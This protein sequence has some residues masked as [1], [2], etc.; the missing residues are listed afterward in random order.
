M[1]GWADPGADPMGDLSKWIET[2]AA[3]TPERGDAVLVLPDRIADACEADPA[4][5]DGPKRVAAAMGFTGVQVRRASD[6]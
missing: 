3:S 5:L 2:Y 1:T 4:L 6:L